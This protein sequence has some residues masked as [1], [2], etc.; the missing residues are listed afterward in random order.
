MNRIAQILGGMVRG[1]WHG[2]GMPEPPAGW[3]FVDVTDRPAAKVGDAY[4]A[5]TDTFTTPAPVVAPRIVRR[6]DIIR[7]LSP[8]Q[9]KEMRMYGPREAGTNANGT[10]YA[11]P[12]VLQALALLTDETGIAV[13]DPNFIAAFTALVQKN[14][15]TQNQATALLAK[16]ST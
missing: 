4:D 7:A 11:D 13:T 9:F 16:L 12:V 8:A 5:V 1:I 3:T 15:L 2:A 6:T 14:V 10:S